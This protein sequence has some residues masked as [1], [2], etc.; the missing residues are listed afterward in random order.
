M[1]PTEEP[2]WEG[3]QF[4]Y[5]HTKELVWEIAARFGVKVG[6]IHYAAG[7]MGWMY[8]RKGKLPG[9]MHGT[10]RAARTPT[11]P[12]PRLPKGIKPLESDLCARAARMGP[13]IR[14]PAV[15][16]PPAPRQ[17]ESLRSRPGRRR[18]IDR[19]YETIERKLTMLEHRLETPDQ[20]APA[21]SER[22]TREIGS[23]ARSF[24]KVGAIDAGL[25]HPTH[26]HVIAANKA[27][28][29]AAARAS[30]SIGLNAATNTETGSDAE[31]RRVELAQ[32]ID[33]LHLEWRARTHPG[34]PS[35]S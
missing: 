13:A 24:E 17:T 6:T 14:E 29:Q 23:L 30:T 19:L 12:P 15:V 2:D 4:A 28:G 10:P 35:G 11:D 20:L 18:F 33:K 26:S 16:G 31:R 21:D 27:A 1:N 25:G 34:E 22:I 32:R 9:S 5:E 7:K 8:R 3:I